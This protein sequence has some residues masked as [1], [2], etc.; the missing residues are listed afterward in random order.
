MK[1]YFKESFDAMD[2]YYASEDPTEEEQFRFVEAMQYLIDTA[3][4]PV[5]TMAFSYNLAAYY[6]S[7]RNFHLEEK[8][9]KIGA[10][11]GCSSA[12]EGL[13]ILYYYGLCGHQDYQIAYTYFNESQSRESKMYLADMYHYGQFVKQ[14]LNRCRSIL[15]DL[16]VQLERERD[17]PHF[18]RHG[19]YPEVVL[20][21]A[22]LNIEEGSV[23]AFDLD[24]L[25]EAREMLTYRQ[26]KSPLW[27][28]IKTMHHILDTILLISGQAH[29]FYD[30]YDLLTYQDQGTQIS[31][32]YN[33]R[34]YVITLFL[35]DNELIYEFEGTWYHGPEDFLERA[36]VQD[37]KITNVIDLIKNIKTF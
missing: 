27:E 14:N 13:G 18:K 30:L 6:H 25:I 19:L 17:M 9:L 31:F 37:K 12:K 7:I 24:C 1:D 28:N 23:T 2:A 21:L 22:Q 4:D 11:L 36:R 10:A 33:H 3:Y 8:Y 26:R 15:Q 34:T 16:Q 29:C 20:R 5:D 35:K 32:E